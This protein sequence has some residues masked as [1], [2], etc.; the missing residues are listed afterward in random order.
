MSPSND[1][2][3]NWKILFFV[4]IGIMSVSIILYF[5]CSFVENYRHSRDPMLLE[6]KEKLKNVHPIVE[7]LKFFEGNKSYTINKERI[8]L[9]LKDENGSY[10]DPNMLMYVALHEL[11]HVLC[12]EIGHTKKF[13]SIFHDVLE[14]AT[15]KQIYDPSKPIIQNYCEY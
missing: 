14:E 7:T 9:C 2:V 3:V 5:I 8:Y 12:D 15:R 13:H 6:I 10:Y 1:M 11:S 4:S